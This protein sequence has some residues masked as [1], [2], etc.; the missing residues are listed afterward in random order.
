MNRLTDRE[1][2]EI[3]RRIAGDILRGGGQPAIPIAAAGGGYATDQSLGVF[4]TV[5]ECVAAAAAAQKQFVALPLSTRAKIIEAIRRSM[6]DN[7]EALAKAAHDETGY[8][9]YEDKV[10]KNR[11]VTEKTPG[12]EDLA[13]IAVSGDHGL[14]L[15]EPAPF[16]VIGAIT[17][18]T[19]PTSTII[20]NTIGMIAAGNSVVFNVHP[21]AKNCC[22]QTIAL[23]NKAIVG[24]GGPPNVITGV[25]N[26]TIESAQEL[27]KDR[28]IRLVVVTG[29]PDVV[30]QA[31]LSGKRAICA[32]PGNPPVVVDES[33]DIDK[34]ARDIVLGG[35]T[36]NT[37]ICTDEKETLAVASIADALIAAMG[38]NNA[39]V[40]PSNRLPE[41]ERVVFAEM[42][43]PRQKAR[44]NKDL[45]GKNANV[46]LGKL[47]ISAPD[48]ARLVVVEVNEDH[49]LLWTEQM[50]PVMPVCRVPNA[51]RAIDLAVEVEG[52]NRHT[53]V[54]HSKNLDNL[55]RM[56][57]ACDCS[58]FVKN[59]R[60]QAGLGLDGE[61]YCSFTIAS[62]TGEGMT[63]P[64]SFSRWRRCVLVDHFRIT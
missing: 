49:P 29:G 21:Y 62:P 7:C 3:A 58:I 50:M 17:P 6:L 42:K 55:S 14:E 63:S 31:M 12:I 47:G 10:V 32:G 34:A 18:V 48:S 54:M 26:P 57:K 41:L 15:T 59:G 35:S 36:D 61:G 2:D 24:A 25:A 19:N 27:M 60:S 28:G 11:L 37:I 56:A 38:R 13:P 51:N 53:A 30:R 43:G 23:I 22:M 20:C 16:G 5:S 64:R 9:R 52:G 39:V 44:L 40:L 46:I 4:A 8:G 1:I 33:A 45:I